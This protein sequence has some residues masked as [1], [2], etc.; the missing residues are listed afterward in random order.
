MKRQTQKTHLKPSNEKQQN[1]KVWNPTDLKQMYTLNKYQQ[2]KSNRLQLFLLWSSAVLKNPL[3]SW[4]RFSEFCLVKMVQKAAPPPYLAAPWCQTALWDTPASSPRPSAPAWNTQTSQTAVGGRWAA[5][6][7]VHSLDDG[8]HVGDLVEKVELSLVEVFGRA[9]QRAGDLLHH[10]LQQLPD[11]G[12]TDR[13]SQR[14]TF[15]PETCLFHQGE[16][17]ESCYMTAF[18]MTNVLYHFWPCHT[19]A[20]YN[21]CIFRVWKFGLLQYMLFIRKS[22]VSCVYPLFIFGR[23]RNAQ[24]RHI[25]RSLNEG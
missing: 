18:E 9:R 8:G 25:L 22:C 15:S 13:A 24:L 4:R 19:A 3:N 1:E 14:R 2:K 17:K 7:L 16:A 5:A 6:A 20:S 21:F 10:L 12:C 23:L 11:V